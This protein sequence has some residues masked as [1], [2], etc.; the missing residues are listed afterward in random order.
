MN[1]RSLV[2]LWSAILASQ[3]V[4]PFIPITQ[5]EGTAVQP[6]LFP[7]VLGVVALLQGAG[8]YAWLKLRAFD[9]IKGGRLDPTSKEG[10]AELFTALIMAWVIASSVG[11]YGL[12]LRFMHFDLLYW[13]PFSIGG[14]LLL[15]LG[16]PWQ[17]SLSRPVSS[18]DLAGSNAPLS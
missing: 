7:L 4:Y 6:D 14:A 9:P 16:R 17:S 13:V 5:R 3:L 1:Q 11:I 8:T 12:V 18:T 2:V 15:F 10:A